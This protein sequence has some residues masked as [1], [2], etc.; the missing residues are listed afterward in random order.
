MIDY[1][2]TKKCLGAAVLIGTL[3]IA[4]GLVMAQVGDPFPPEA[5]H[6]VYDSGYGN[7]VG[8]GVGLDTQHNV[9]MV[10]Y[11]VTSNSGEANNAYARKYDVLG[12]LACEREVKGPVSENQVAFGDSFYGVAVDSQGN[13]IATGTISGNWYGAEGYHNAMYLNKFDSSCNPVWAQPVIYHETSLGDSAWQ[14][15]Y[16]VVVDT[17]DTIFPTGRVFMSWGPYQGDW[18][19]WKY[20][21]DGVLQAGF[22]VYYNYSYYYYIGDYSYD[23][24]VD[25]LGNIIVV[26]GRGVSGI[27]G[28]ATNNHDWHVRKYSPTGILLWEDTYGGPANLIDI[29]YRVAVDSQNNVII[30]G[31]TNKGTNNTSAIDYDWLVIKYAAD[32]IGGAGERL[33]TYTYESDTGRSEAAQ[34]LTVDENDNV[35]VGGQVLINATTIHARLALLDGATGNL[36]GE[37]IITNPE[38]LVPLR[39]AFQGGAIAIGGYIWDSTSTNHNMYAALLQDTSGPI[40]PI[41]PANGTAFNACSYYNPPLFQWALNDTFQKLE[42]RIFSPAN[43]TK[44]VKVKVKDPTAT[45][46]QMTQALWK[47]VLRL[48]GPGEATLQWKIIGSNKGL[49]IVESDVFTMTIAA[50]EPAGKPDIDPLNHI[51]TWGNSCGTKFKAHFS[52]DSAFSKSKKLSFKYQGSTNSDDDFSA[53]LPDK[54]WVSLEKLVEG[55]VPA[56]LYFYVESWDII[57][58]YQKTDVTYVDLDI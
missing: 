55:L 2:W 47:K 19:T 35:I 56:R 22:P 40:L 23:I 32:G 38:N 42:I 10:G 37:R 54:T 45:Q 4:P 39:L 27:E 18:A 5:W 51:A 43:A 46:F 48:A 7:D 41:A 8:Y 6:D 15:A 58:R 26:G 49:P 17:Y 30:V 34:A 28:G 29:A 21:S 52:A 1:G 14:E 16:S 11:R 50:P 36:L 24:A 57:K 31:Y 33:W 20:N 13:F 3:I 44:P 12:N 53:T 9:V 25:S